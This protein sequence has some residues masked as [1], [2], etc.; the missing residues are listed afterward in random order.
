[1]R[2]I[3]AIMTLLA[4][5]ASGLAGQ[6]LHATLTE[7]S[8]PEEVVL[9]APATAS[10]APSTVTAEPPRKWPALFG[11]IEPPTPQ[12][13]VTE[14][15]PPAP[16]VEPQP[17]RPPIESLGFRLRGVVRADDTVWAMVSHPTGEQVF[18]VGDELLEGVV[19]ERIDEQG[20]WIDNGKDDLTLLGF[21]TE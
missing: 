6:R 13:P 7:P 12:P 2:L 20:L 1:M 21:V 11:E 15:Q 10:D 14:P 16:V 17:P 3:A 9:V 4:L 18:R 19:I 8:L 5:A